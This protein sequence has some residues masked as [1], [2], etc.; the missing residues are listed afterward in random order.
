MVLLLIGGYI[1]F[2]KALTCFFMLWPFFYRIT[3]IYYIV[4]LIKRLHPFCF[5]FDTL[6]DFF[7]VSGIY[8]WRC[9]DIKLRGFDSSNRRN[10]F[11]AELSCLNTCQILIKNTV[12]C[13]FWANVPDADFG[14]LRNFIF[15]FT[16]TSIRPMNLSLNTIVCFLFISLWLSRND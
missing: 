12:D 8:S 15:W 10:F 9:F 5:S 13:S 16:V 1:S 2:Q 11:L 6:S 4:K 14:V 7:S 3:Q